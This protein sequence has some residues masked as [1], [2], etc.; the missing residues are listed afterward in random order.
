ME[1]EFYKEIDEVFKSILKPLRTRFT[2][3]NINNKEFLKGCQNE[4]KSIINDNKGTELFME[5]FLIFRGY[6]IIESS[7]INNSIISVEGKDAKITKI[8]VISCVDTVIYNGE[9]NKWEKKEYNNVSINKSDF[10]FLMVFF[11]FIGEIKTFKQDSFFD[12]VEIQTKHLSNIK[13][14]TSIHLYEKLID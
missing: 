6:K 10:D 5:L 4:L 8:K 12:N 9:E 13:E 1:K 3:N 7:G 11:P 2:S 14:S